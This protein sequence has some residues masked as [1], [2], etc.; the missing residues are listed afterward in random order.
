[1]TLEHI[2]E[3]PSNYKYHEQIDLFLKSQYPRL[4]SKF[5]FIE[6]QSISRVQWVETKNVLETGKGVDGTSFNAPVHPLPE[7]RDKL[8]EFEANMKITKS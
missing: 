1:M 7:I 8:R 4:E 2:F 5:T 6:N 3:V